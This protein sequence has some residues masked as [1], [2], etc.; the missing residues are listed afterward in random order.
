MRFTQISHFKLHD[1]YQ[2]EQQTII[3]APTVVS[4]VQQQQQQ[5]P[6]LAKGLVLVE[7]VPTVVVRNFPMVVVEGLTMVGGRGWRWSLLWA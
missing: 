3:S 6:A 4:I 1:S 5:E 7:V 2:I